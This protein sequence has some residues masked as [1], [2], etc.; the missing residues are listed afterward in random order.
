VCDDFVIWRKRLK[1]SLVS[2]LNDWRSY[3]LSCNATAHSNSGV[4]PP[5]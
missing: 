4:L 3:L 5:F 2:S 1:G